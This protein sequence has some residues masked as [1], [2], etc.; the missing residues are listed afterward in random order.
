MRR[1]E[2]VEVHMRGSGVGLAALA[3]LAGVASA[4]TWTPIGPFGGTVTVLAPVPGQP[5]RVLA[6]TEAGVYLS[7][8]RGD[9]WVLG[10]LAG[11]VVNALAVA[12]SDSRVVYVAGRSLG[13]SDGRIFRSTDGGRTWNERTPLPGHP[14]SFSSPIGL[15]IAVHP[16]DPLTVLVA[17]ERALFRSRNGGASW[18]PLGCGYCRAVTIDPASPDTYYAA[19]APSSIR[20]SCD[21]VQVTRDGG[22]TWKVVSD[23]LK[24]ARPNGRSG[25]ARVDRI[26]VLPGEGPPLLAT[27]LGG[28]G[29][30]EDRSGIVRSWDG[31]SH[32][33]TVFELPPAASWYG[34]EHAALA[35]VPGDAAQMLLSTFW[36]GVWR[37]RDGGASW[38]DAT[39]ELSFGDVGPEEKPAQELHAAAVLPGTPP[40]VLVGSD[41]EGVWVS[42]DLGGHWRQSI[43]GLTAVQVNDLLVVPEPPISLLAATSERAV[44]R[45]TDGGRLWSTGGGMTSPRPPY[46]GYSPVPVP[47]CGSVFQ[48][49]LVSDG[50][51]AALS[52]Q[53]Y[54]SADRG[55][56]WEQDVGVDWNTLV[57]PLP[58]EPGVLVAV[59]RFVRPEL[60]TEDRPRRSQD[61]GVTWEPCGVLPE[62][63]GYPIS[64]HDAVVDAANGTWIHLATSRGVYTSTD[65]CQSWQPRNTGLRAPCG[66]EPK[67]SVEALV[68]SPQAPF[69]LV[70]ATP[71]GLFSSLDGAAS[72]VAV[73]GPEVAGVSLL[74][75][76]RAPGVLFA[77]TGAHGV[78]RSADGGATWA[79]LGEGL[80]A[81]AVNRLL[82]VS[83]RTLLAA[84]SGAGA[85]KLELPSLVRRTVRRGTG[86]APSAAIR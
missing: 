63:P 18:Q 74:G 59:P 8:D 9:S 76:P 44:Q 51:V 4:G 48:L 29:V 10:G 20:D 60:A 81:A 78:L 2:R 28:R 40:R 17:S 15:D 22:A 56:T 45:T 30:S 82:M 58:A 55:A 75:D 12:P 50:D 46:R 64:V 83:S 39:G 49:A 27:T 35:V 65:G 72:W 85:W 77:G 37:S 86:P 38:E 36:A 84:T 61:G 42:D 24:R 3:V 47:Y 1:Y 68:A 11:R 57:L 5:E 80:P 6:G 14:S 53:G 70:A 31:G 32:W 62:L 34:D 25:Y 33:E 69:R 16:S 67:A 71:C 52:C 21:G 19:F 43:Q 73:T 79:P 54:R 66:N 26:F 23:G 41:R 13:W 7:E